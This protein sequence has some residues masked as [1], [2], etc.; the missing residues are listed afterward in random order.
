MFGSRHIRIPMAIERSRHKNR[1]HDDRMV[2]ERVGFG[3]WWRRLF[4]FLS[5]SD[6]GSCPNKKNSDRRNAISISIRLTNFFIPERAFFVTKSPFRGAKFLSSRASLATVFFLE[7]RPA[8]S[9]PSPPKSQAKKSWKPSDANSRLYRV[10][11]KQAEVSIRWRSVAGLGFFL[12]PCFVSYGIVLIR[13]HSPVSRSSFS[14][15]YTSF[16]SSVLSALD[17]LFLFWLGYCYWP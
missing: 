10:C 13:S 5:R 6:G 12:S 16:S 17:F 4:D 7:F 1:E 9:G 14:S 8:E 2:V 11:V 3:L 15:N